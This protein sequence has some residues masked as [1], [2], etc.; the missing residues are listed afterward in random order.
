M[1]H[2][3]KTMKQLGAFFAKG[4]TCMWF[5]PSGGRDRRDAETGKVLNPTPKTL[6]TLKSDGRGAETGKCLGTLHSGKLDF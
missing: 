6:K 3:G 4:G 5:A 2:N 1:G